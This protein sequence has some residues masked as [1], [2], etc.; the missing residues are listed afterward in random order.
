MVSWWFDGR[1]AK[2]NSSIGLFDSGVGG[3]SVLT[4]VR[5]ELPHEDL[6]YFADQK[7]C[8]YG[9]RP[10]EEI[11]ALSRRIVQ[12]LL[13]H[14]CKAIVVACNTASAA[15]LE[16]LREIFP[17][18]PI[19]G[20]EP[21]VKPAAQNSR[22]KAIGVLATKGTFEGGLFQNT[23]DAYARDVKVLIQYPPDWVDRV[24]R[25]DVDSPQTRASVRSVIEPMRDAG[26]DE[27]ALGCTHYPFLIP[28]IQEIAG[29]RVTILD[30]SDAVARQTARV[31]RERDLLNRQE[32]EGR[33]V[34]Y[35]SG[36][37]ASFAL[38]LEKLLGNQG[39]VHQA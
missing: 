10:A 1:L 35:T 36:D 38:V 11:R 28:L 24:E 3:L 14:D 7:Y 9:P 30:P 27:L 17:S 13:E 2:Q 20:M 5:R 12:F 23:R 19:I 8:P 34:Y 4:A 15:A 33:Q 22:T 39:E 16:Y 37:P 25:G 32:R 31:L 18:L 6:I 29:S 26:V 21:A